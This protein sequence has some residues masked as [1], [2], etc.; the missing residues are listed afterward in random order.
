MIHNTVFLEAKLCLWVHTKFAT[1]INATKFFSFI[2]LS[3]PQALP[4]PYLFHSRS[5]F[6]VSGTVSVYTHHFHEWSYNHLFCGC[7]FW[8]PHMASSHSCLVSYGL[9]FYLTIKL[10]PIKQMINL[11]FSSLLKVL[12]LSVKIKSQ[13][14][15]CIFL[16]NNQ[17]R[18]TSQNYF[19]ISFFKFSLYIYIYYIQH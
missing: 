11:C 3:C 1:I 7:K 16:I 12:L 6:W 8:S 2:S 4:S 9:L 14:K 5:S 18:Y 10:Y 17:M 19:K 15:F 13:M